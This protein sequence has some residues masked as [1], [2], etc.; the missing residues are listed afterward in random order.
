MHKFGEIRTTS[1]G[2]SRTLTR[3]AM[4]ARLSEWVQFYNLSRPHS[5][6]NG[7]APYEVLRERL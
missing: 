1:Y 4:S 3:L 6:F 2:C 7:K 5:A